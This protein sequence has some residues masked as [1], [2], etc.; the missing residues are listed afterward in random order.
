MDIPYVK[1]ESYKAIFLEES[2][3]SKLSYNSPPPP[4]KMMRVITQF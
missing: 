3:K 2:Y 4:L 1:E